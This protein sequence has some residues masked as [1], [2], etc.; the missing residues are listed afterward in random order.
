MRVAL[1]ENQQRIHQAARSV[2]RFLASDA[3]PAHKK[4]EYVLIQET[5]S[6]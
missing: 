6:E 4:T 3:D 1:V 5:N 2:R